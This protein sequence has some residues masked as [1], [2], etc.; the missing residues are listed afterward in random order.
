VQVIHGSKRPPFS[1]PADGHDKSHAQD[2]IHQKLHHHSSPA[3]HE[4]DKLI[5]EMLFADME[6]GYD[7]EHARCKPSAAAEGKGSN[8]QDSVHQELAG[9]FSQAQDRLEAGGKDSFFG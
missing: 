8:S 7:L 3:Y 2:S 1:T 6:V 5:G 9:L 4:L